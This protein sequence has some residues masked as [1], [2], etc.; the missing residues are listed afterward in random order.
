MLSLARRVTGFGRLRKHLGAGAAAHGLVLGRLA[1][2][3]LH[4]RRGF[5]LGSH[6]GRPCHLSISV[7]ADE[8]EG[9]PLVCCGS[10]F[11]G[12]LVYG[13]ADFRSSGRLNRGGGGHRG[14]GRR[15][16]SGSRLSGSRFS[17]R[18][19]FLEARRAAI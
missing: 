19:N 18:Q 5:G 16:L 2:G 6:L 3:L 12:G 10:G 9:T 4:A 14:I 15:R 1:L 17:R 8:V 7:L 11:G 13:G